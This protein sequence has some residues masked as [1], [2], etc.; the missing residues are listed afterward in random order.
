MKS[1]VIS[2]ESATDRRKH[3][4][5]E[6]QSHHIDF[7]FFDALTPCSATVYAQDL[8]INLGSGNLTSGELACMMSHVSVWRKMIDE[9]IPYLAIFEDDVYL[10]KD[11]QYLLNS[12]DW[13]APNWHIIKIEAFT[14]KVFLSKNSTTIASGQRHITQLTGENLG[15]AGYILSLQGAKTY[16]NYIQQT[17][18]Q[19]LDELMFD[20][21]IA[22]NIEPV[23]QMRPALCVQEMQ[24]YQEQSLLPSA[25][26]DARKERMRLEK[27]SGFSK[28]EREVNRLIFQ[29]KKTLFAKELLFK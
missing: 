28:V 27:K 24:L 4:T 6:F 14:K 11:A 25:L 29:I 5:Q 2:L 10:G 12:A 18:L 21:F 19:P 1:I 3:I 15:T 9:N 16:L 13:I 20:D 23:Y 8:S 17:E 7:E 26:L 22:N